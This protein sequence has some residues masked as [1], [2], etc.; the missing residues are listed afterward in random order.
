MKILLSF[1]LGFSL[2][3][4]PARGVEVDDAYRYHIEVLAQS[5]LKPM[6]L[7]I[8][9]DGR[10]FVNDI[11]GNLHILDPSSGKTKIAGTLEVFTEQENGFLGFALDPEF[12]D[13]QWIYLFYSPPEYSGQRLS[14]FRME[15]DSLDLSS[16]KVML[17]FLVQRLQCCHHAGT[18]EFAPDGNLLISTGDNTFPGAPTGGSAPIDERPEKFPWDA[19]KSSANTHDLRGKI[20]RIRP[21]PEGGYTIPEGNLFPKDGSGGRPEIFVM[22][23]RNPWRM[24]VDERTGVVYWGEVGPDAGSDSERG[25]RGYDEIN[26]ARMAG[27]FGWPYFVGKNFAYADHDFATGKNGP[28]YDPIEPIN[29]SPYNTGNRILPPAQPAFIYWPY[30]DSPEF[31]MLGSGGRTACAGPVFHYKPEFENSNGFP[32]HWDNCLLFWDWQRPFIKWARLDSASKLE[33]IEDFTDAVLLKND[34]KALEGS[35]EVGRFLIQRPVD[36]QFGPDG[37]LYLL[38]YGRTW[39]ANKD[40]KLIKISYHRGN[41]A[42]I[43]VAHVSPNAGKEP[44][45]IRL[46][47]E[48]SMDHEGDALRYTWTVHPGDVKVAEGYEAEVTVQY[49][50]NYVV[51]LGVEDE[52]GAITYT[53]V[54]LLVGNSRPK[55]KLISPQ[56][57]DFFE[58]DSSVPYQVHVQDAEDGDSDYNDEFID[59]KVNVS[60]RYLKSMDETEV[61]PPGLG[62]MRNSDCLNCHAVNQR[63]VGPPFLEVANRYRDQPNAMTETVERVIKGSSGVWGEVPMLPHSQLAEQEVEQMVKWIY[64]L[65]PDVQE[66]DSVRGLQGNL[67]INA[68]PED[69]FAIVE[70]TYTDFGY[71]SVNSLTASTRVRL[72]QRSVEAEHCDDYEGLKILGNKL[73]AI[74]DGSYAKFENIPLSQV[75]S[76]TVRVASGGSGC[77]M[78]FRQGAKDGPVLVTFQVKPTGGYNE[79]IELMAELPESDDRS[80]IFITFHNP[81]KG[82]LMDLDWIRFNQ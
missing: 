34:G 33:G 21:T 15:G 81:G 80:D 22:G 69:R 55:V 5:I 61:I 26:Q 59:T 9:P 4:L 66:G 56:D 42:P 36:A 30:A 44:L 47:A 43:A 38:D 60:T 46:S 13:N 32:E 18:V 28:K 68:E 27:N 62:A 64:A 3:F 1:L 19:Q 70:A 74:E 71:E 63:I 11:G 75:S 12:L 58:P 35:E 79:F 52:E 48:G 72:R 7:E 50:G 14:R 77:R 16:E 67:Q 78:S 25:P 23:C 37:C 54:P 17:E 31:P 20:L 10:I 76:V 39:G 49:P 82:G 57:G 45:S 65:S 6:E 53:S 51:T 41:I 8:A 40:S 2:G 24:S 29:E 73:G